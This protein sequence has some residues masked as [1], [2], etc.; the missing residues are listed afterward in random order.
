MSVNTTAKNS[1]LVVWQWMGDCWVR[2]NLAQ[3][4]K[5]GK[6]CSKTYKNSKAKI[7]FLQKKRKAFLG[8]FGSRRGKGRGGGTSARTSGASPQGTRILPSCT[9]LEPVFHLAAL[10]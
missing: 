2:G 4:P 1:L 3:P 6:T 9:L 7:I 8:K 5:K 10:Y